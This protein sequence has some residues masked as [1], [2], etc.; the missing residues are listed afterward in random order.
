MS[1]HL[2]PPAGWASCLTV[3][4]S[5][6]TYLGAGI[7]WRPAGWL[8]EGLREGQPLQRLVALR[9][10]DGRLVR[11]WEE[12]GMTGRTRWAPGLE[13]VA[14]WGQRGPGCPASC[15]QGAHSMRGVFRFPWRPIRK[16]AHWPPQPKE[17]VL[18]CHLDPL[19][20]ALGRKRKCPVCSSG[21][22]IC[23]WTKVR[24][25]NQSVHL[26]HISGSFYLQSP[27]DFHSG[28]LGPS[29]SIPR[30]FWVLASLPRRELKLG[31]SHSGTR[32]SPPSSVI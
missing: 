32:G 21:L 17:A 30:G 29:P 5:P 10:V 26:S 1:S 7:Q 9:L 18:S 23:P 14:W 24:K 25:G 31:D 27:F 8:S 3:S 11:N 6:R 20:G 22:F 15:H 28:T 12:T 13:A 19:G 16:R 4:G 2:P